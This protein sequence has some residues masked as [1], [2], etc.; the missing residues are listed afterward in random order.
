ML[1]KPFLVNVAVGREH[2]YFKFIHPSANM[3]HPA[4]YIKSLGSGADLQPPTYLRHIMCALAA[5]ASEAHASLREPFYQSA[6]K[7]LQEAELGGQHIDKLCLP[8]AQT[9]IL[10]AIYE[11]KHAHL[12][13]SLISISQA[14]RLVQ[15]MRLHRIDGVNH[16]TDPGLNLMAGPTDWAETEERRRTFWTTFLVDRYASIGFG[17]PTLINEKDVRFVLKIDYVLLD[18]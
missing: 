10:I 5:P 18:G 15:M 6:R 8:L 11:L 1:C 2:V 13:R 14:V 12:P 3:I 16:I 4:R 7:R 9:A 17:W